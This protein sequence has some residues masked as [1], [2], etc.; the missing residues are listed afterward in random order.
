MAEA[1]E[2]LLRLGFAELG[3]AYVW[4]SHYVENHRSRRVIEKSGLSY[5]MDVPILDEPTGQE[6]PARLYGMSKVDWERL[7][8]GEGSGT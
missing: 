7:Q 5:Q 8:A 6:K 3:L 4:C 1:V 2:E